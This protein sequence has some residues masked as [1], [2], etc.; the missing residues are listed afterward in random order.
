MAINYTTKEPQQSFERQR[1][2]NENLRE[3][4]FP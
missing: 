4:K 2:C 1:N 3:A